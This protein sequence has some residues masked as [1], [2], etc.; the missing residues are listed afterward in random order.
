MRDESWQMEFPTV[1]LQS[2]AFEAT[3]HLKEPEKGL[4]D[5]RVLSQPWEGVNLLGVRVA[6]G[7]GRESTAEISLGEPADYFVQG[8]YCVALYPGTDDRPVELC[9]RWR[10]LPPIKEVNWLAGVELLVSAQTALLGLDQHAVLASHLPAIKIQQLEGVRPS[11]LREVS[12]GDPAGLRLGAEPCLLFP[13]SVGSWSYV[14]MV[15]PADLV[16]AELRLGPPS[17]KPG[18]PTTY[19]SEY[20]TVLTRYA[21]LTERLEKGIILRARA[22]ACWIGSPTPPEAVATVYRHLLDSPPP[23]GL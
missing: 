20:R 18:S 3:L 19:P 14:E 13:Q 22:R 11:C 4:E 2:E 21:T 5:C 10:L 15:H 6:A 1:R 8:R 12:P 16:W 9:L 7:L 17:S 23:L